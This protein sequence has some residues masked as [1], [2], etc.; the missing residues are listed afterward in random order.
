[1]DLTDQLCYKAKHAPNRGEFAESWDL[2]KMTR[3]TQ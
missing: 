1:M 3:A 2:K